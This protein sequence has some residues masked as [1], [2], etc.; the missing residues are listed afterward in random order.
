MPRTSIV[1]SHFDRPACLRQALTSIAHQ[2][3]RD[4]EVIVVNDHGVDSRGLV[5]AFAA[6]HAHGPR[7][8][9]VRYDHR[10][11][12]AGV[13]ATRNRGIAL[14]TGELIA[15]L[16][17]DDLWRPGHLAALVGALRAH[18]RAGLAYGDALV[19]RMRR[20]GGAWRRAASL[21]LA[22]PYDRALM[23]RDDFIVPG[24]MVH[25]RSL[26]D[27]VGPFDERLYVSDDWDWLLRATAVTRF[28]RVPQVVVTVRIWPGGTNL[29]ACR[30]ERRLAA[31]ATIQRRHGTQPLV[32][33]TFWEVAQTYDRM[34]RARERCA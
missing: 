5:E 16:D 25:R 31:L 29:S 17:D 8:F 21:R 26:Y 30:D 27:R 18:R 23:D 24:G 1:V 7:A 32:P 2:T 20:T 6:R 11:R 10:P 13:A 3:S 33:K 9:P 4:F 15:H 14:A 12:N 19:C 34:R 28:V 22:V